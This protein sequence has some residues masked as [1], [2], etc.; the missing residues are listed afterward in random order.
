MS[1]SNPAFRIP[2]QPIPPDHIAH[3][4]AFFSPPIESPPLPERLR[5]T[6]PVPEFM[7]SIGVAD[8]KTP[9]TMHFDLMHDEKLTMWDGKRVEFFLF[10]WPNLRSPF[11]G[12]HFPAPTLRV[13]RGVV[14]HGSTHAHGPPPHTIHWHGIEPTP[15]NDGV[16][17]C[18]TE[19]GGDY[20]YQWQPNFT[21]TYFYHCHRN[22]VQHFEFGLYGGLIVEPPDA[23]A[24][25]PGRNP[26]G[27]PRRTVANVRDFPQF[28]GFNPNPLESGDPQAQTVPYDVE[29]FW[30]LSTVDSRWHEKMD[31]PRAGI[32]RPGDRPGVN[33][34]WEKADFHDYNSDYWF[35]TGQPFPGRLGG[36]ASSAPNLVV[37]RALN[38]GVEGMQISVNARRNQTILVR[39]LAASYDIVRIAFPVDVLLIAIDGRSLGSPPRQEYSRPVLLP[40][41]TFTEIAAAQRF[42][43]LIRPTTAIDSFATVQFKSNRDLSLRFTGRIPFRIT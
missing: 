18:S 43:V 40:A 30:V 9:R 8:V 13:P 20:I 35:V 5:P 21:G 28:P 11:N 41:G 37:P 10:R 17:H 33:D 4:V 34:E 42:D 26:G 15:I 16:G 25:G 38:C 2:R 23:F 24:T 19:L 14:F 1:V 22:T 31:D 36:T 29:A 27:Y 3:Y 7:E 6:N 12:S 32:A 39:V